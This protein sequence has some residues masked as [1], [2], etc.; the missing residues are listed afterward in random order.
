MKKLILTL[1]TVAA[2]AAVPVAGAQASSSDNGARAEQQTSQKRT[3]SRK[4]GQGRGK[5]QKRRGSNRCAKP[6]RVGFVVQGALASYDA[7][8]V[9]LDVQKVNRHARAW[10]AAPNPPSFATEGLRFSFEGV[11]DDNGTGLGLDDVVGTDR[12]RVV[13][14]LLQPKRGCAGDSQLRLR[15]VK[16]TREAPA[17][18]DSAEQPSA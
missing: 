18:D 7:Q 5:G 17:P 13:G 12:V 3:Q 9:T 11:S 16:V 4:Q 2:L 14:K 10:L 6:K 8:S 15:A 1:T